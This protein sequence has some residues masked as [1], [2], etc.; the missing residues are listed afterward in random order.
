[1][2]R[3]LATHEAD[4]SRSLMIGGG[5]TVSIAPGYRWS[6]S[7]AAAFALLGSAHPQTDLDDMTISAYDAILRNYP[8]ALAAAAAQEALARVK[9]FPKAQEIA[10]AARNL[11]ALI[12]SRGMYA[13][14]KAG[15]ERKEAIKTWALD[16]LE[17]TQD[18][19]QRAKTDRQLNA[20]IAAFA[21][22]R[23]VSA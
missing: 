6:L 17:D 21:R 16:M 5:I 2:N 23:E 4:N 18:F 3:Q 20:E 1:M 11:M 10:E 12:T 15:R 9:W 8:P 14:D 13:T 19:I 7:T 22:R